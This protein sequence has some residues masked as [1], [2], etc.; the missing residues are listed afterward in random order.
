MEYCANCGKQLP[1]NAEYCFACDTRVNRSGER[2]GSPDVEI[3]DQ[4]KESSPNEAGA[5][6][7]QTKRCTNCGA[8]LPGDATY[9]FACDTRVDR[10]QA[11]LEA[12]PHDAENRETEPSAD[13]DQ[14]ATASAMHCPNC[15]EQLAED[16][17]YCAIC[18]ARVG[19]H[20]Q[21]GKQPPPKRQ[22]IPLWIQIAVGVCAIA[23]AGVLI[24]QTTRPPDSVA[25][26]SLPPASAESQATTPAVPAPAITLSPPRLSLVGTVGRS[27][28]SEEVSILCSPAGGDLT[29]RV[30]SDSPWLSCLPASDSL[31]TGLSDFFVRVIPA[32]LGEGT[33]TGTLSLHVDG[34][35]G[36][37]ATLPVTLVMQ[38]SEDLEAEANRY[39]WESS[40]YRPYWQ[41]GAQTDVREAVRAYPFPEYGHGNAVVVYFKDVDIEFSPDI[42]PRPIA[43]VHCEAQF[44]VMEDLDKEVR[45]R[46]TYYTNTMVILQVAPGPFSTSRN[47]WHVVDV[48]D[49]AG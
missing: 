31:D 30:T 47:E 38:A 28:P 8:Q 46:V 25:P 4:E 23:A 7:A 43:R 35:E 42:Y 26:A 1:E 14:A 39:F 36:V 21:S 40:V 27:V 3:A 16:A 24:W 41:S 32:S 2:P 37:L 5:A 19:G 13:E 22:T 18:G 29:W 10:G 11:P 44:V 12:P 9:C 6:T 48:S 33:H 15:G 45:T 17:T 20:D 49:Y 34:F